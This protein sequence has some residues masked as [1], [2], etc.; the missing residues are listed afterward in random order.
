M[1]AFHT[2]IY[3][4]VSTNTTAMSATAKGK[5]GKGKAVEP[6]RSAPTSKTWQRRLSRARRRFNEAVSGLKAADLS[7]LIHNDVK[8]AVV[9]ADGIDLDASAHSPWL[10]SLRARHHAFF[11]AMP[12]IRKAYSAFDELMHCLHA[13][14]RKQ[15]ETVEEAAEE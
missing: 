11:D 7:N 4:T 1:L 15:A 9:V 2:Q 10:D 6:A 14:V 5:K 3:P 13:I 8:E 12:R